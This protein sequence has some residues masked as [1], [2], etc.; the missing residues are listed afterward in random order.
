MKTTIKLIC[1]NEYIEIAGNRLEGP[2][3]KVEITLDARE[4]SLPELLEQ[5]DLFVKACG[6]V[7]PENCILDYIE[8]DDFVAH[9]EPEDELTVWMGEKEWQETDRSMMEPSI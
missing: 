1:E 8:N 7:P 6:Y 5:I 3:R 4:M 2:E 9:D